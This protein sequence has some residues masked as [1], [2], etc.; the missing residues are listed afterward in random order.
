MI[1]RLSGQ[2]SNCGISINQMKQ[3]P[4]AKQ[5]ATLIIVTHKTLQEN[6][7]KALIDIK[8]LKICEQRPICI[9]IQEI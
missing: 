2:L 3:K 8:K 5:K 1:A 7:E 6:L 9:E 4:L